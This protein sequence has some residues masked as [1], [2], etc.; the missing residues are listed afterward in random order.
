M[1]TFRIALLVCALTVLSF[2]QQPSLPRATHIVVIGF[3]GLSP[4]G[5]AEA[6]TPTWDRLI[7]NGA[8]TMEARAVMPTSSSSNWGSMILGVGPEQHGI[9]SNDWQP[10]NYTISPAVA[11]PAGFSETMFSVLRRA[12]PDAQIAVFHDWKDFGRLVEPGVPNHISHELGPRLTMRKAVEY[13]RR[14]KPT[15]LFVHLDHIDTAG[16]RSG[17]HTAVYK[18]AVEL[19]DSLAGDLV[20]AVEEAG[21]LESTAFLLTSDHGG[22]G[23]K[24]GGETM[25]ELLIP[26]VLAGPGIQPSYSIRK[27]MNTYD[28]ACTALTVLGVAPPEHWICRSLQEGFQPAP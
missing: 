16:H 25:D 10:D 19:G 21:L 4:R 22:I 12:R 13:Y 17:W 3:D 28:T 2:S 24:H 1:P 6:N 27:P 15:M 14:H 20:S 9:T 11:G 5:I 23:T 8:S 7:A 18:E 26:W